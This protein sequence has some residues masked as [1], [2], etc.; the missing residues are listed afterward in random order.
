[1][2]NKNPQ[3]TIIHLAKENERL[4]VALKNARTATTVFCADAAAIA[5]HDTFKRTGDIISEF[6]ERYL[7]VVQDI[8]KMAVEDSETVGGDF[9][10]YHKTKVDEAVKAALGEK[11]FLPFNER[12][13]VDK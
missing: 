13:S 8:A 4:R 3:L 1:M 5:A 11:Y 6:M 12:H 2:G 10:E 7:D 9:L